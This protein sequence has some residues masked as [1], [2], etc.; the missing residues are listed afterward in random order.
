MIKWEEMLFLV[1]L[2]IRNYVY[3]P[4]LLQLMT[5]DASKVGAGF[6][7]FQLN[8]QGQLELVNTGSTQLSLAQIRSPSVIRE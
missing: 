1:S 4:K 2:K 8:E 3:R 5:T 6:S 7:H